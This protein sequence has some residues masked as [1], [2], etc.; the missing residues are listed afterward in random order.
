MKFDQI[1]DKI[2]NLQK[3]GEGWRGVVY[4]GV[5]NGQE[6]A[7]KVA[8]E[9]QFIKNIQKEGE[10]LK[11]V[12]QQGIG[13][14]LILQGEDFIAYR[15]IE[16]RPL[17]GVINQNNAKH[18]IS[19][20]LKQA[21]KLDIMG[22]N[23]EELHRPYTNVLIDNNMNVYLID[24]ERAK[25]GKNIQN[26]NQ[27]LQFVMNAGYRYLQPFD[28]NELISLAREYKKNKTEENFRKILQ[29]LQIED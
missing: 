28:K 9:P 20:L 18:I 5:Y 7:F 2:Q 25:I 1:K 21:R 17:I 11:L 24:F 14:K 4:K 12:N 15:F 3:I 13:G 6:L 16:G 26:V 10:I 19:Q 27:V 29:F 23:K 22:I 8:S